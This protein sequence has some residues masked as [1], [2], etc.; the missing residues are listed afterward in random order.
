MIPDSLAIYFAV[1]ILG[2]ITG[3]LIMLINIKGI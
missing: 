2:V 3:I 1:F